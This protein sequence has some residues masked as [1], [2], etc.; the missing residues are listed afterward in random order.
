MSD[1][2]IPRI[3]NYFIN[4]LADPG[5]T[6]GREQEISVHEIPFSQRNI[7]TNTGKKT[8]EI[9]FTCVFQDNPPIT[10][11]QSGTLGV[12]PTYDNHYAFL[13]LIDSGVFLEFVHPT[14]GS[15]DGYIKNY[16]TLRRDEQRYIEI[17]ISFL[18]EISDVVT[19]FRFDPVES[20]AV[21]F[22]DTTTLNQLNLTTIIQD[23]P[24]S[25]FKTRLNNFIAD[26]ESFFSGVSSAIDSIINTVD[27]F[28]TLAGRVIS[29]INETVDRMVDGL[30]SLANTASAFIN[31]LVATARAIKA[32]F[33]T[34]AGEPTIES[35]LFT[36]LASARIS[37][38]ASV[39][40]K[41]DDTEREK[42]LINVGKRTFDDNGRYLG[43]QETI[44]VMSI[45]EL[46]Q[47]S[48]DVRSL[49]D[50]AVQDDRDNRAIINQAR[51]IQ[52]YI[53][54]IKL[55]RDQIITVQ[56]NTTSLFELMKQYGISY[57]RAD[58]NLALNP[59]VQNP[60]FIS[61]F[62]RLLVPSGQ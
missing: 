40:Y 49:T 6:D 7:L 38:E 32:K 54:E 58:E 21:G 26:L 9:T 5:I 55:E 52:Q 35:I 8:E 60:N 11:G 47:T 10:P 44:T 53:D 16:S 56:T 31:N 25:S 41:D 48:Q 43:T 18:R 13:Q 4:I 12:F 19:T 22:R 24:L 28:E 42:A 1:S 39:K 51:V 46:E 17:E 15:Y 57:Q 2:Y 33:L 20:T 50:E 14:Y 3:N 23:N 30:I 27:Y 29:A 61:G 34:L 37:Y 62:I 59:D 45:N 36:N